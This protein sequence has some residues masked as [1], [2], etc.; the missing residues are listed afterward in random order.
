MAGVGLYGAGLSGAVLRDADLRNAKLRAVVRSHRGRSPR[1]QAEPGRGKDNPA[2]R[3]ARCRSGEERGACLRFL[4][5]L[6]VA[7][8][9][10]LHVDP[11]DAAAQPTIP[12]TYGY[13]AVAGIA[14]ARACRPR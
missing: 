5:A 12:L 6:L 11:G 4:A 1:C 9:V 14:H 8:F 13:R 10:Y 3:Q 7:R 2:R